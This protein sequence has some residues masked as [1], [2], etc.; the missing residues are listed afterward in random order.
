MAW[1]PDTY[2]KF[3]DERYAPFY[4]LLNL[5]SVKHGI[6]KATFCFLILISGITRAQ[7]NIDISDS[8]KVH[9]DMFKVKLGSQGPGKIWKMHFGEYA[10][11]SSKMGWTTGSSKSNLFNTKV[12]SKSTQKFSFILSNKSGD[13]A[14]VSAAYNIQVRALQ[15][16][17]VVAGFSWG[18]N[19]LL[20]ESKNFSAYI[21]INHDTTETWA[22]LIHV[23]RGRDSLG[24]YDA[25]LTNGE[26]KIF[27]SPVR[28]G[29]TGNNPFKQPPAGYEFFER[30]QSLGALQYNSIMATYE[31]I[32]WINRE[33]DTRMKLVLAA[34]MTA[35]LQ[36]KI[37]EQNNQQME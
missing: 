25:F 10:V 32:V 1:N 11:V 5:I 36:A 33:L 31:D 13:S 12:E 9:A 16:I 24:N 28:Q 29:T 30:G 21:N 26:R 8:L 23:A 14:R 19:E 17:E 34:S 27:I 20:Q 22:L 2:N 37:N 35:I 7:K 4:D 18:S 6:M 3:K 15:E